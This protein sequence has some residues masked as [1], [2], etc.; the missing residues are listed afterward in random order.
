MNG[1]DEAQSLQYKN[2]LKEITTDLFEGNKSPQQIIS[3]KPQYESLL[4]QVLGWN[5]KDTTILY[6]SLAFNRELNEVNPKFY[7]EKVNC[8]V[9]SIYGTS[10]FEAIDKEYAT[11]MINW[12]NPKFFGKSTSI[13]LPDTDHAF[14]RVGTMEEGIKLKR[15]EKY[16]EIM[17]TNF[18][19]SII[20]KVSD[21][22]FSL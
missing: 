16:R 8:P 18:N 22:I 6:R 14:A 21:W 10:D 7:W 13:I 3:S 9:L 5:E 15:S 17:R 4:R 1:Y 19:Q 20:R 12:I 11:A 2:Y